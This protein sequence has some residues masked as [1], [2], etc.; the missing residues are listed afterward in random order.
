MRTKMVLSKTF[1]MRDDGDDEE[2][3]LLLLHKNNG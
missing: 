2:G 1:F 3:E